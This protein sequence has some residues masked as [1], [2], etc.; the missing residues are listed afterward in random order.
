[1]KKY[2]LSLI[3]MSMFF[4]YSFSDKEYKFKREGEKWNRRE[5]NQDSIK[6]FMKINTK[7]YVSEK[8]KMTLNP[9]KSSEEIFLLDLSK[10]KWNYYTLNAKAK[11]FYSSKD[12]YSKELTRATK[13]YL[14]KYNQDLKRKDKDGE[15]I[16]ELDL[17]S[18]E[19]IFSEKLNN[20]KNLALKIVYDTSLINGEWYKIE[21]GTYTNEISF[22]IEEN[23]KNKK[24]KS[25][26]SR[27]SD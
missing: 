14:I 16:A 9:N 2:L 19:F 20:G 3:L 18:N 13:F 4:Q 25:Y 1:M 10:V 8:I 6:F 22:Y 17:E 5:N 24:S 23:K 26:K 15:Y 27:R 21:C 7:R 11:G 12:K